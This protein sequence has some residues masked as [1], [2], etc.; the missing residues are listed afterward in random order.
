MGSRVIC[1]ADSVE[2]IPGGRKKAGRI[3]VPRLGG[4]KPTSSPISPPDT[5]TSTRADC[6]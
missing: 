3:T 4:Q 5:A 2:V 1:G 6:L